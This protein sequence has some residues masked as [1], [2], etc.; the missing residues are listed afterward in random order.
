MA[1][2]IAHYI[3]QDYTHEFVDIGKEFD[4]LKEFFN[5]ESGEDVYIE[6]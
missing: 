6:W 2:A 4:A 1:S 5:S 3:G